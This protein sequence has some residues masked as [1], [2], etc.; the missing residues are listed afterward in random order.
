MYNRRR[1]AP[2]LDRRLA[3]RRALFLIGASNGF[4]AETLDA[5]VDFGVDS[6]GEPGGAPR[7]NGGTARGV[8]TAPR[9]PPSRGAPH[10]RRCARAPLRPVAPD[11][12]RGWRLLRS[13]PVD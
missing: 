5:F 8:S 11:P 10:R 1:L 12:V 13:A 2:S 4:D 6:A 3:L 9:R 7:L